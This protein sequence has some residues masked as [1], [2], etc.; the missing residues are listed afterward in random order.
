M[1]R[2]NNCYSHITAAFLFPQYL[3]RPYKFSVRSK[4]HNRFKPKSCKW[5]CLHCTSTITCRT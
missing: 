1:I 5:S 4:T 2:T 3:V